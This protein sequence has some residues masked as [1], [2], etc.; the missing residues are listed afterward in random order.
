MTQD[1]TLFHI[2]NDYST[3]LWKQQSEL[4]MQKHGLM[5]FIVHPDYMMPCT[6]AKDLRGAIGLPDHIA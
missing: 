1:Y 6:C 4:I 2:L 5:S 3:S